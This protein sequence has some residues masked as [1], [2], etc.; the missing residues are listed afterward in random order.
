MTLTHAQRKL[1]AKLL[2]ALA[3]RLR[4]DDYANFRIM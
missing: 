1:L 2:P 3:D 4:I